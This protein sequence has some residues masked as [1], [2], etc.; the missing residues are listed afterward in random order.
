MQI[1]EERRQCRAPA[2]EVWKLLHDPLRFTEWWAGITGVEATSDGAILYAEALM[3][4]VAIPVRVTAGLDGEQ[5]RFGCMITDDVYIWTLEP[6]PDGCSVS[7][8]V[9]VASDEDERVHARRAEI[10][11]SLP[12]LVAAAE[13]AAERATR[14]NDDMDNVTT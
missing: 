9:D 5:M 4:G 13:H 14:C 11:A 2:V 12:R 7:V 10:A 6:L 1:I 3:P 8:H